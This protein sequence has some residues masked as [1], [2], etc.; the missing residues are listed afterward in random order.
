MP[1]QA[2]PTLELDDDELEQLAEA[3]V[4]VRLGDDRGVL[5]SPNSD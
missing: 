5:M 2:A 4:P 1:G 3:W